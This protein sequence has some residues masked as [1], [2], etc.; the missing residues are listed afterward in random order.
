M[1]LD[2][3]TNLKH[4][5]TINTKWQELACNFLLCNTTIVYQNIHDYSYKIIYRSSFNDMLKRYQK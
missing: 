1:Y 4:W 3:R 2:S 5:N